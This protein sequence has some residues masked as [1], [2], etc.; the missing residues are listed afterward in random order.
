MS[1]KAL[2]TL[3]TQQLLRLLD[4]TDTPDN[5]FEEIA[6]RLQDADNRRREIESRLQTLQFALTST[7]K[8]NQ[9]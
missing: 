3:N 8:A 1:D 2:E 4:K 5:L 6:K 9:N 7:L